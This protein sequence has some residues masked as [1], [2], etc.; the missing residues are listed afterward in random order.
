MPKFGYPSIYLSEN[1]KTV[2]T[3]K[4]LKKQHFLDDN[5]TEIIHSA[6]Q[7][8]AESNTQILDTHFIYAGD[9]YMNTSINNIVW[10]GLMI[11]NLE[12]VIVT[13]IHMYRDSLITKEQMEDTYLGKK[14][15]YDFYKRKLYF[16]D[17]SFNNDIESLCHYYGG[18]LRRK[19]YPLRE[20]FTYFLPKLTQIEM[21]LVETK[22]QD[23][24]QYFFQFEDPDVDETRMELSESKSKYALVV[25]QRKTDTVEKD[26]REPLIN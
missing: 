4:I 2:Q 6:L 24:F 22:D 5:D 18:E 15:I 9:Y 7:K 16:P 20:R 13:R 12:S 3:V 8:V 21:E 19:L 1:N 11:H 14:R 10:R 17:D 25:C 23:Y 26:L